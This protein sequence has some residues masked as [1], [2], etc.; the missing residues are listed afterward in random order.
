MT[1]D[2]RGD[3]I[4]GDGGRHTVP[5]QRTTP[6]LPDGAQA[7]RRV[8]VALWLSFAL[9]AAWLALESEHD[10][11]SGR[12]V[13]PPLVVT[14]TP[15]PD[16]HAANKPALFSGQTASPSPRNL[17]QPGT[18]PPSTR[19]V[20]RQRTRPE[21]AVESQPAA[22]SGALADAR[23]GVDLH[24]YSMRE[25]DTPPRLVQGIAPPAGRAPVRARVRIDADGRV[26]DIESAA[27]D[28]GF[29]ARLAAARFAPAYR[30]GRPV[31]G[32]LLLEFQAAGAGVVP[33]A[34]LSPTPPR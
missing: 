1:A 34:I 11:S 13:A 14:L 25:L 22:V 10:R 2:G 29:L 32:E 5:M 8:A 26:Q 31:R 27:A 16:T 4:L 12:A 15:Q 19:N 20:S 17:A 23:P 3:G 21:T 24:W 18:H 6:A 28:S 33:D 9:H 7:V 30:D